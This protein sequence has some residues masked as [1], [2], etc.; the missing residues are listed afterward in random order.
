[1]LNKTTTVCVYG[2]LRKGCGNHRI[3]EMAKGIFLRND[4]VTGYKMFSLGGF[5]GI[6]HAESNDYPIVV[7]IYEVPMEGVLN[8][9]DRLEGYPHFYDREYIDGKGWIYF[10]YPER[11]L[12]H[13][14]EEIK[15]GDW[16]EYIEQKYR[17]K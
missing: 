3:M 7:E 1:L 5:P 12:N 4:T 17:K 2:T 6:I 11:V 14:L 9:L 15:S 10:L 16:I 8:N 13:G